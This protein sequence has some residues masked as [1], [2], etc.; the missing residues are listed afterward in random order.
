MK[1]DDKSTMST[2]TSPIREALTNNDII[3]AIIDSSSWTEQQLCDVSLVCRS[4]RDVAIPRLYESMAINSHD[5][6]ESL[7]RVPDDRLGYI[8]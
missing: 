3:E 7:Q 5:K 8:R 2:T 1:S 4:F 6:V